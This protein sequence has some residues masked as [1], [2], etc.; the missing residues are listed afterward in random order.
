MQHAC[1]HE[2]ENAAYC[3]LPLFTTM[4]LGCWHWESEKP[5]PEKEMEP[6]D[7]WSAG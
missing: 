7:V 3:P 4:M 5:L 1:E 6:P 2:A